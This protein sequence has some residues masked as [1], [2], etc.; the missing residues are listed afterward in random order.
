MKRSKEYF[1]WVILFLFFLGLGYLQG[2]QPQSFE[3]SNFIAPTKIRVL[4]TEEI[5]F[6]KSLRAEIEKEKNVQFEVIVSRQW[7]DWLAHLISN[8]SAD[9]LILPSYWA[10]S[11]NQQN[12]LAPF[13][14]ESLEM[15]ERISPNFQK[16]NPDGTLTFFPIYW[17]KTGFDSQRAGW[18]FPD[19]L[20]DKKVD[21]LY[22]WSDPDLILAHFRTW[23]ELGYW[24]LLKEKKILTMDWEDLSHKNL[25]EDPQEWPLNETLKNP[26]EQTASSAL[27]VWGFA[28]PKNAS[29]KV[30]SLSVVEAITRTNRQEQTLL[31]LPFSTTLAQVGEK[32]F[33]QSRRASYIR[34]L[35]LN[36][37]IMIDSK[38]IEA[39]K[40]L[41]EEFDFTL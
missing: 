16:N 30:L 38:N 19:Y 28:L 27:I 26:V 23:K 36:Q 40:K 32:T 17:M 25:D 22:I 13:N 31:S 5:L 34:D 41:I 1:F 3:K 12:L 29:N 24:P 33:P 18:N 6:P 2:F 7:Q 10:Q 15:L 39:E 35:N 4:T 11:L 8:D 14:S 21:S 9:L 20:K 37:T